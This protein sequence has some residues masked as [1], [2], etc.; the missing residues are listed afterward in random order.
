MR[1]E[2]AG[3]CSRVQAPAISLELLQFADTRAQDTLLD[4]RAF[5]VRLTLSHLRRFTKRER[6]PCREACRTFQPAGAHEALKH[7]HLLCPGR[8]HRVYTTLNQKKE[9]RGHS[10]SSRLGSPAGSGA[11]FA[12][13]CRSRV[14]ERSS[15]VRPVGASSTSFVQV[16]LRSIVL[17]TSCVTACDGRFALSSRSISA[18]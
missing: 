11:I 12:K 18:G 4:S 15:S 2:V 3:K 8:R 14:Y 16:L 5:W 1:K 17:C 9:H 13:P 7:I 6:A 10:S